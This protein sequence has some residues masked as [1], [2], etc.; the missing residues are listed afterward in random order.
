METKNFHL[1]VNIEG[2]LK[3]RS[4]N[5]FEDENGNPMSSKAAKAMLRDEQA[6]GKKYFCGCDN[7]DIEGKCL[8]HA[9]I[10]KEL[11]GDG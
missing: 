8:G 1:S 10:I 4:L 7:V 3:L 9:E 11:K 5:I 2:A 6:K